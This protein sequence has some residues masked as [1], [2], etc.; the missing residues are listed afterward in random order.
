GITICHPAG[1][2]SW[3]E[4]PLPD[5]SIVG[6]GGPGSSSLHQLTGGGRDETRMVF[7]CFL[8]VFGARRSGCICT[9]RGATAGGAGPARRAALDDQTSRV[10]RA[11]RGAG[12]GRSAGAGA[13][14]PRLPTVQG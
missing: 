11:R 4:L 8:H 9:A 1:S 3:I 6:T 2:L 7:F 10:R 12:K 13:G 14:F 5:R